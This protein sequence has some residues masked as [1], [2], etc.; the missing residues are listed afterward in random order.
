MVLADASDQNV[1]KAVVVVIPYGNAHAVEF[2]IESSVRRDVGEGA[3]PVVVVE[4][5]RGAILF[6][7]GPVGAVDQQDVLPTIAIVIQKCA[8]RPKGLR[9]VLAAEGAAVVLKLNSSGAGYVGETETGGSRGSCLRS[10]GM[11]MSQ[12]RPRCES[13]HSPQE[14]PAIH[15]TFTSPARIAYTTN[16]AVLWIPSVFI[17]LAR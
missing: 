4:A 7:A 13:C 17:M 10:E 15:G 12:G 16:S 9:Q 6:V 11:Q 2:H 1:G 3:V 5:K 14:K 8:A